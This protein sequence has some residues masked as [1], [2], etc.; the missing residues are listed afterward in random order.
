MKKYEVINEILLEMDQ[1][2]PHWQALGDTVRQLEAGRRWQVQRAGIIPVST[3]GSDITSIQATGEIRDMGHQVRHEMP[4]WLPRN[5]PVPSHLV[6]CWRWDRMLLNK[7]ELIGLRD[8]LHAKG[9]TA[10][11]Q[12]PELEA[13][14]L[15]VP[16]DRILPNPHQPRTDFDEAG[17]QALADS[18]TANGLLQF[19]TV[20]QTDNG[21]QL[22]DGERRWRAAALAGRDTIPV[23]V[24]P[25]LTDQERL[26]LAVES[27]EQRSNLNPVELAQALQA[28]ADSGLSNAQIGQR[29]GGLAAS[30]I[31]NKRRLLELPPEILDH[32]AVGALTER[33]AMAMLPLFQL[34]PAV[35]DVAAGYWQNSENI[36]QSAVDGATS[37]IVRNMVSRLIYSISTSLEHG[38][39]AEIV[40]VTIDAP[41]A[42][43]AA[44]S[45]CP[46]C[47][48]YQKERRCA[49][50]S[51]MRL[52]A[53][54]ADQQALTDSGLIEATGIKP[55]RTDERYT[56]L[57][58]LEENEI[59]AL[60]EAWPGCENR[61]LQWLPSDDDHWLPAAPGFERLCRIVCANGYMQQDCKCYQGVADQG[62]ADQPEPGP[63]LPAASW[64]YRHV[65]ARV[66]V[67]HPSGKS[68][69]LEREQVAGAVRVLWGDATAAL[70][71]APD[72]ALLAE[73]RGR[74]VATSLRM[75]A[76]GHA[77]LAWL[78]EAEDAPGWNAMATAVRDLPQGIVAQALRELVA[79]LPD[80][81]LQAEAKAA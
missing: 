24:R 81:Q 10:A 40:D 69:D 46:L 1:E 21:Y 25:P 7:G 37:E 17:L 52:K 35:A 60:V 15:M 38:I 54:Y 71:D 19:P 4:N 55:L 58:D 2:G 28:L 34:P 77:L 41:G 6:P 57:Y 45:L 73:A 18:I 79:E 63:P 13:H 44:C 64:Q 50:S 72:R 39:A 47:F 11:P 22:I 32:V 43:A 74:L 62:V 5:H 65:G 75:N 33:Q 3:N 61:R 67:V 49:R 78:E 9:A 29:L 48:V 36:L 68:L 16:L 70:L 42:E 20:E 53:A 76:P 23:I 12:E 31:S 27:N 8:L 26:L 14:L 66:R 56:A 80:E 30:T 59:A 51:C